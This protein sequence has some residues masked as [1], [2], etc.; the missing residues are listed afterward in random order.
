MMIKQPALAPSPQPRPAP[1]V[2]ALPPEL[3][4]QRGPFWMPI[5]GPNP[6]PIDTAEDRSAKSNG[7]NKSAKVVLNRINNHLGHPNRPTNA[8]QDHLKAVAPGIRQSGRSCLNRRHGGPKIQGQQFGL[9]DEGGAKTRWHRS[10]CR[11]S[12]S[13]AFPIGW[14]GNEP[15]LLAA[16]TALRS[17]GLRLNFVKAPEDCRRAPFVARP[18]H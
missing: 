10:H 14:Q 1:T 18:P 15:K 9:V 17:V 2:R 3:A 4:V 16:T 5:R 12:G 13:S 6:T 8:S 7:V 11:A